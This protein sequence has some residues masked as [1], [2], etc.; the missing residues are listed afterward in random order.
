MGSQQVHLLRTS[1]EL[2]PQTKGHLL[3]LQQIVHLVYWQGSGF[4]VS[5]SS[6][7]M[8]FPSKNVCLSPKQPNLLRVSW[9]LIV[10]IVKHIQPIREELSKVTFC[11]GYY[12]SLLRPLCCFS[13][14]VALEILV[15]KS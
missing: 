7:V 4:E 12:S 8:K 1:V 14:L 3:C 2:R 11:S 5:M 15:V 10:W 13:A 9:T 6:F